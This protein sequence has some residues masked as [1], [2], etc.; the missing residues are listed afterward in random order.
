MP[1]GNDALD[2]FDDSLVSIWNFD[3][4][5]NFRDSVGG[6]DAV[7][8]GTADIEGKRYRGRY[9]DGA[10][11]ID[12]PHDP[13]IAVLTAFSAFCWAKVSAIGG[14]QI[15]L[16]KYDTNAKR[17]YILFIRADGSVRGLVS[18]DGSSEAAK[19]SQST[20]PAAAAVAGSWQMFG[21]TFS[22]ADKTVRIYV[23]P[24][25]VGTPSEQNAAS[26]ASFSD[27]PLAMG[28]SYATGALANPYKGSFDE[29]MFWDTVIDQAAATALAAGKVW[30]ADPSRA[31]LTLP[32]L[33]TR[34]RGDL[35]DEAPD[36]NN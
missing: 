22:I 18:S 8:D 25:D 34:R 12:V 4:K 21:M 27:V 28:A 1:F 15:L 10:S 3:P 9:F 19:R 13:S 14:N 20:S 2:A 11:K 6:N 36:E 24:S 30:E 31:G 33:D 26:I 35:G 29:A 17:S 32:R 7:N 5:D 23:G 16:S